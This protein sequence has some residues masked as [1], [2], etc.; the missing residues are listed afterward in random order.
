MDF[1]KKKRDGRL[2]PVSLRLP[3]HIRELAKETAQQNSTGDVTVKEAEVYREIIE[4]FFNPVATNS[5]QNQIEYRAT[6]EKAS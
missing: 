1:A 5:S 6:E 3:A 4:N 2:I